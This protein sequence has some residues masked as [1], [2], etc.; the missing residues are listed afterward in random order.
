[1]FVFLCIYFV[2]IV[3][4]RIYHFY[5]HRTTT[6]GKEIFVGFFISKNSRR[7]QKSTGQAVTVSLTSYPKQR[8]EHTKK[9]LHQFSYTRNGT[10]GKVASC[11]FIFTNVHVTRSTH[12]YGQKNRLRPYNMT[13]VTHIQYPHLSL[14]T[15]HCCAML[16]CFFFPSFF[17]L[18]LLFHIRNTQRNIS[19]NTSMVEAAG[20]YP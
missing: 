9:K 6:N 16:W 1:M 17:L 5:T 3:Q 20:I 10:N 18:L 8:G 12:I 13:L 11:H 4:M 7:R 2:C 19:R 15:L 14:Y